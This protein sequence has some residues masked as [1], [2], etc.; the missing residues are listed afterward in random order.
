[1]KTKEE[2]IELAKILKEI[3]RLA[4]RETVCVFTNMEE[5]LGRTVGNTLEIVETIECLKGNMPQDI[6]RNSTGNWTSHFNFSRKRPR[7]GSE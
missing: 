1:M 5:P 4:G 7:Y 3:G 2:A 6:R